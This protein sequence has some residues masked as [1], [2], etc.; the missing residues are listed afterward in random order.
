MYPADGSGKTALELQVKEFY[1]IIPM[2]T[3]GSVSEG[4]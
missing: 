3:S 4:R 2:E 1:G